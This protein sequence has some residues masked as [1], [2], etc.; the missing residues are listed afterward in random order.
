[1]MLTNQNTHV[2]RSQ[3]LMC[4]FELRGVLLLSRNGL[5]TVRDT[6]ADARESYSSAYVV[7]SSLV[8]VWGNHAD[9]SNT[10][11]DVCEST[12]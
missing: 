5:L 9:I 6:T 4:I 10:D 1:M 12:I 3:R 8:S 7:V 2:A 11:I